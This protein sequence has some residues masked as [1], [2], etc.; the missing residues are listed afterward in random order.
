MTL[1]W[2][3]VQIQPQMFDVAK[4]NLERQGFDLAAPVIEI[5]RGKFARTELM[6]RG[7]GFVQFEI[8]TH[9][10]QPIR[11]TRGVVGLLPH[12]LEIPRPM[13][14][15]MVEALLERQWRDADF[16]EIF[17]D[18]CPGITVIE[19]TGRH[20]LLGGRRGLVVAARN[21]LLQIALESRGGDTNNAV[22]IE[23]E[24]ARPVR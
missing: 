21:R 13:P 10:W 5:G 20:R 8:G 17:E 7:Y 18:Y 1:R 23:R 24:Y 15:G 6:F 19:V 2:Y 9:H 11:G 4:R 12:H 22:W 16:V 3:T 14:A